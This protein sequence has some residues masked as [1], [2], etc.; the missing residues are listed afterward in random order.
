MSEA[1]ADPTLS[2]DWDALPA[3]AAVPASPTSPWHARRALGIGCSELAACGV[4]LGALHESEVPR[5][6]A[7]E[8]AIVQRG[9]GRGLPRLVARKLGL[10]RERPRRDDDYREGEIMAAFVSG[11]RHGQYSGRVADIDPDS[12]QHSSAIPEELYPLVDRVEPTLRG[13]LDGWARDCWGDLVVPDWKRARR[14][15]CSRESL[16]AYRWQ[17]VGQ[18]AVTGAAWG[19]VV[20]GVGWVIPGETGPIEPYVVAPTADEIDAARD[21]ARRAWAMVEAARAAEVA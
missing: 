11:L 2:C 16:T 14:S 6:A 19:V 8:A 10:V 12:V 17:L 9:P 7:D 4:I 1:W 21:W 5:S 13:S 3:D 20:V 15:G 18:C